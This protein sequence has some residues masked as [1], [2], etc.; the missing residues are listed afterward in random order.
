MMNLLDVTRSRNARPVLLQD[1]HAERLDF[2]LERYVKTGPLQAQI[3]PPD[4][5]EEGRYCD[6]HTTP[7][8]LALHRLC[9]S[10]R[11]T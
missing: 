10:K 11:M 8:G 1:I 4:A 2:A 9:A 3:E 7:E 6:P 5:G